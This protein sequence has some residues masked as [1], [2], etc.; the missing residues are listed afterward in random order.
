MFF[1]SVGEAF[2]S[3]T[4]YICFHLLRKYLKLSVVR[5]WLLLSSLHYVHILVMQYSLLISLLHTQH[6]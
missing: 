4:A 5:I 1:A 2:A 6:F 3:P